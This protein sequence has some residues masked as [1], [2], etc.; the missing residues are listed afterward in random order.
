MPKVRFRE[1]DIIKGI[2]MLL[3]FWN[4][5][6]LYFPVN[7]R[8]LYPICK[9]MVDIVGSWYMPCF[10]MVSGFLFANSKKSWSVVMNDKIRRLVVP[11]FFV[12]LVSLGMKLMMPSMAAFTQGGWSERL[13]YYFLEGGDRWFLY[14]LFWIFFLVTPF[15]KHIVKS[16]FTVC[17]T[18]LIIYTLSEENWFPF[19][20][21]L[22]RVLIFTRY[23]LI[24]FLLR[25][26]YPEI[27][28]CFETYWV[29]F[30][31]LFVVYNILINNYCEGRFWELILP[32]I[33]S[34]ACFSISI[35]LTTIKSFLINKAV[36]FIE[37]VGKYSLQFYIMTGF[38]LMPA[39]TII[40]MKLGIVNPF[41]VIPVVFILQV[42]LATLA[43]YL[44]K[45]F[46]LMN[47]LMG[48]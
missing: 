41:I 16:T 13:H 12:C 43:V 47:F 38:V 11:Y 27:R 40:V 26:F 46:K 31:L 39:R 4:H 17:L 6:I 48:Y 14:I 37:W 5:S 3:V 24:G 15:R 25:R 7:F 2:C 36:D 29:L 34:F 10:F 18:I 32:I 1:I 42:A 35:R 9:L 33:G 22:Q 21:P 20:Y 28:K 23:F 8:E 30:L 45:K 19:I 44:C